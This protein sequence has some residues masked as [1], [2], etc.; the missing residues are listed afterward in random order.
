MAATRP[1]AP[2]VLFRGGRV[3]TMDPAVADP[4]VVVVDAGRIVAAGPAALAAAHPDAEVHDLAGRTL[5]PG[6]IDAHCHL[7]I[8]ALQ[9]IWGDAS[10]ATDADE[11][12]LVV[13]DQAGREPAADWIRVDGW[14][15]VATGLQFDRHDLDAVTGDR[16]AIVVHATYHQGVVNSAGLDLLGI[17]RQ[18]G[19]D[20]ELVVRDDAGAPTGLLV[21]RAFGRAHSASMAAYT[22][23]E[24]WGRHI[25]DR[26]R[27]LLTLG[28]TGVHDAAC[29]PATEAVYAALARSGE[30]PLSVLMMPH[31]ATFL[32]HDLG[33]RLDGPPTG[34][35]DEW[36]RVGPVKLFADGGVAPAID[37][38]FAG[39]RLAFGYRHPDLAPRL[40]LAVER[41]FRVA[42]HAMGNVGI[43]D[44]LAAFAGAER[45]RPGA[46]HRFRVEHAGL[47]SPA[48]AR[49]MAAM[50]AVG[51]V[52]PGFVDHVGEN[53]GDF[54]PDDA[55]WLPFG[56]LVE[57]GVRLAGSSDDPCGPVAPLAAAAFG[58][59]R[60]THTGREFGI[61][62]SLPFRD[63]LEAY[64]VGAAYAGGQERERGTITPGKRADLVV[65]D[66]PLDASSPPSV[67]ETWVAGVR[68]T[69]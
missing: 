10:K 14:D 62:Q 8:A 7:S 31:P 61:D 60:R 22:E 54:R 26:A 11:L 38:H 45:R 57:A 9:P 27:W 67:A 6:F 2:P 16:P 35:G 53:V 32:T 68:A 41:G 33:A 12:G 66:G 64:T 20:D 17:G 63:W 40:A 19:P 42:V 4:D 52:Q 49:E 13:A 51:V 34:E 44:T 58:T 56:A 15:E 1:V 46:D 69:C 5:V 36:L 23:P 55:A 21:E 65:L 24:R 37:V 3:L 43:A 18:A 47:A 28:V 59:L 29:D 30:L 39:E 50:G 25:V 48:L